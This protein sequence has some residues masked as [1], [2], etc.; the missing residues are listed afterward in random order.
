VLYR[1]I[2][3]RGYTGGETRVKQFMR[4]LRP[5]PKPDPVVRFETPPGQQMQ[6]DWAT[7]GRGADQL[8]VLIATLGWSRASYVEFCDDER[9]DASLRSRSAISLAFNASMSST[10][11][12]GSGSVR[13]SSYSAARVWPSRAWASDTCRRM[14]RASWIGQ[15]R[16]IRTVP[17]L[18]RN[19]QMAAWLKR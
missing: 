8:S 2:K 17:S 12:F 16:H 3:V 7:I 14:L 5:A 6:V 19:V 10:N 4:G 13:A 18:L 9:L 1:E 11:L 15:Q